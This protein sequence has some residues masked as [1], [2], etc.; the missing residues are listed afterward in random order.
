MYRSLLFR[1]SFRMTT[2]GLTNAALKCTGYLLLMELTISVVNSSVS[3]IK[4]ITPNRPALTCRHITV[5][6][7]IDSF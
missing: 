3:I 6:F 2:D 5:R 1:E 7:C 4:I